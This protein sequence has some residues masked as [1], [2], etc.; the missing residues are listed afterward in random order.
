MKGLKSLISIL[1]L[2]LLISCTDKGVVIDKEEQEEHYLS[3]TFWASD[4]AAIKFGKGGNGE[5]CYNFIDVGS[6]T[7]NIVYSTAFDRIS[8][9]YAKRTVKNNFAVNFDNGTFLSEDRF[10]LTLLFIRAEQHDTVIHREI[11]VQ[12]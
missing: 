10:S 4:S 8:I 6:D 7:F 9:N 11:F 1:F 3:G 12:K 5:M 2:G